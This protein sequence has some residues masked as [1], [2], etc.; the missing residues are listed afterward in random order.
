M[1]ERHGLRMHPQCHRI[2]TAINQEEATVNA[3]R[4]EPCDDHVLARLR[5]DH[6][7]WDIVWAYGQ[8]PATRGRVLSEAEMLYGLWHVLTADT[9]THLRHTQAEQ[10]ALIMQH[11]IEPTASPEPA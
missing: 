2:T 1:Y 7:G 5:D 10:C 9:A 4:P 11:T 8:W 6:P 3:R